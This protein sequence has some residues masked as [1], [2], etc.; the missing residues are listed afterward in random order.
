MLIGEGNENLMVKKTTIGLINK[1][2]TL[3]AQHT[4]FVHF[5]AVV[6]HDYN[7]KWKFQNIP[8]YTFYGGNVVHVVVFFVFCL[9]AFFFHCRSFSPWWPLAFLIFSSPLQNFRVVFP[10]KNVSFCFFFFLSLALALCRSFLRLA[11]LACCLLSPFL[12]LSLSL[13]SK[14]VGTTINLSLILWQHGCR[15][16]FRFRLY[17]LFSCLC[18]TRLGWL[19]DFK[20]K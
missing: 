11:S 12:C 10:T 18:F 7:V 20:P 5:F 19:C 4:F 17:W 15:N 8:S 2:A 9:F 14:F 3:Q 13:Y 6:L 1:K 16:N